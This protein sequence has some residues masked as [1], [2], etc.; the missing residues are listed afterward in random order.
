MITGSI[1]TYFLKNNEQSNIKETLKHDIDNIENLSNNDI[2]R[3]IKIIKTY[4]D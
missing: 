3:L 4:R 1:A 2:E